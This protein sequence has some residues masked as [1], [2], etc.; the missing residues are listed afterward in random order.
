MNDPHTALI[1]DSSAC[2]CW[3][4]VTNV[5]EHLPCNPEQALHLSKLQLIP[6]SHI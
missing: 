1:P 4:N 6:A 5:T 2:K 3:I